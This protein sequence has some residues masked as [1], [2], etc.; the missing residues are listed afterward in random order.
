MMKSLPSPYRIA[1][2]FSLLHLSVATAQ[3][4]NFSKSP[5][6]FQ[7]YPRN[8]TSNTAEI[9]ISGTE[10]MG[11][12]SHAVLRVYRND[13]Q[14]GADVVQPLSYVGGA[15]AFAFTPTIPAELALY[16]LEILVRKA[17]GDTSVRRF[18]DLVAGDAMIIQGQSNA[19]GFEDYSPTTSAPYISPFVRSYG[20]DSESPTDTQSATSWL[21]AS[22]RGSRDAP[23]AIGQWGLV[24]GS[25]ISS[26]T[27]IPLAI[28]NGSHAGMDI[29]FFQR[30][31][32]TPESLNFN[33][34]R[35]L[36]RMRAAGLDKSVRSILFY[37]GEADSN[38]GAVHETGYTN[39]VN[40]W[41][42]DYP[43]I[44]RF[45][46]FQVRDGCGVDRFNVDMR[47]RQRRFADNLA[48][49]SVFTTHGLDAHNGCH[50]LFQGGYEILGMNIARLV[51][52]DLYGVAAANAEAPNPE[53]V[54][55]A[56]ENR[57]KIRIILRNKTDTL[58]F[59]AGAAADFK[60][61]GSTA[62]ITGGAIV[63]G[64]IELQLSGNAESATALLYTGHSGAGPWVRN[65]NGIGLLT[66]SEP[67]RS[68]GPSIVFAAPANGL[69]ATPGTPFNISATATSAGS[70]VSLLEIYVG[71]NR[72]ASVAGSETIS[73]TFTPP[74]SPGA[75]KIKVSATDVSGGSQ[76]STIT[77][78]V[79]S[80]DPSNG[81]TN[82]LQ[83]WLRPNA[84]LTLDSA[85]KV[86][87]W[88]DQSG[89][90]RLLSQANSSMRPV[91]VEA[92]FG[93]R[94]G[95]RYAG[96]HFLESATGMPTGSY[97]KVV[98]YK[99]EVDSGNAS[100]VSSSA[101]GGHWFFHSSGDFTTT[102]H[103]SSMIA[104]SSIR[105]GIGKASVAIV[106]YDASS[107]TG[108]IFVDGTL[109]ATG[110]TTND[111]NS[112][113]LQIGAYTGQAFFNGL[114]GEILIYD[115]VL[116]SQE[117]SSIS[118]YFAGDSRNPFQRWRTETPGGLDA[119]A[120][121]DGLTAPLEYALGTDPMHSGDGSPLS[122]E[123]SGDGRSATV[124]FARP[125]NFDHV[126]YEI[127]ISP[128]LEDWE[129]AT[130]TQL[131]SSPSASDPTREILTSEIDLS[132]LPDREKV[133]FRLGVTVE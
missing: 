119:D 56:G 34:G 74:D 41:K 52:R 94:P 97:T 27:G 114:I 20:R 130:V 109:S 10:S 61:V 18:E 26:Q 83:V 133:F 72:I 55:L 2:I 122:T 92:A 57:D 25:R 118:S 113:T 4:V 46:I 81:V 70:P 125:L 69:Q 78:F 15:A 101:S 32:D 30:H 62:T 40:G 36:Y 86:Q 124:T 82:G 35:L 85:G 115:R 9:P 65:A 51:M 126:S 112:P 89:N 33:Y 6:T 106:T 14:V 42:T 80:N 76:V 87:S 63:A 93:T 53:F 105:V 100:L 60:L 59:D 129:P 31:P 110:T 28:I 99:R 13:V 104:F 43:G 39:L 132:G 3:T 67:I 11:G 103:G 1:L 88:A 123:P 58:T 7:L 5:K 21:P 91:P 44:E 108:K 23:A 95:L 79:G 75:Y 24:M 96:A 37:Q 131:H 68:S 84:G 73:G 29:G 17:T 47:N 120:D 48:K 16:D 54:R 19:E 111:N 12:Y 90:G 102:F 50:L 127:R 121:S 64:G 22:G 45:Y 116:T 66:F 117:I 38:N 77:V 8:R 49:H 98:Q 107:K 128:N 71:A